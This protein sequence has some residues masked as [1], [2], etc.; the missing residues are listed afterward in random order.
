MG[1]RSSRDTSVVGS[2]STRGAFWSTFQVNPS[3]RSQD[4]AIVRLLLAVAVAEGRDI[5][6]EVHW[7]KRRIE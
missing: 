4:L 5:S 3:T 7:R 2:F 1:K 6:L